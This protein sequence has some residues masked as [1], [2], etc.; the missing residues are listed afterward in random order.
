MVK[1]AKCF[2]EIWEAKARKR[3][4]CRPDSETRLHCR[5]MLE[6]ADEA[7]SQ[8]PGAHRLDSETAGLGPAAE[9][10]KDGG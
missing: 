2:K 8:G 5:E 4:G 3:Q 6:K 7:V 10:D 1:E 9:E